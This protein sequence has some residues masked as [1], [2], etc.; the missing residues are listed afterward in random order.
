MTVQC[1]PPSLPLAQSTFH[2]F[3]KTL[4]KRLEDIRQTRREMAISRHAPPLDN[5]LRRDIGLPDTEAK[6]DHYVVDW[7]D[8]LSVERRRRW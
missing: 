4:R 7:K 6:P 5:H 8:P 1:N 3:L 2:S